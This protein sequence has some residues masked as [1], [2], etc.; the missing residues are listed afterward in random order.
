MENLQENI[1]L[2]VNGDRYSGGEASAVRCNGN[3]TTAIDDGKQCDDEWLVPEE[4]IQ[5]SGNDLS[6]PYLRGA[7]RRA[8]EWSGYYV[9]TVHGF[10]QSPA[11][12][13][14]KDRD[15][16]LWHVCTMIFCVSVYGD[17]MVACAQ[18]LTNGMI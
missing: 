1:E 7:S 6:G 10:R 18:N 16:T 2:L 3:T 12:Y 8:Y 14:W 17:M 11:G 13:D 15:K 9:G 5:A 4:S